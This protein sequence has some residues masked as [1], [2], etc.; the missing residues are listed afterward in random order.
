MRWFHYWVFWGIGEAPPPFY[1]FKITLILITFHSGILSGFDSI[2]TKKNLTFP[3]IFVDPLWCEKNPHRFRLVNWKG[4]FSPSQNYLMLFIATYFSRFY[5]DSNRIYLLFA[6][7]RPKCH[8]FLLNGFSLD[9][10]MFQEQLKSR[11]CRRY[12]WVNKLFRAGFTGWRACKKNR[13]MAGRSF[14]GTVQAKS[15]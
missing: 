3:I 13:R 10:I 7:F 2:L 8:R 6:F 4:I 1:G 14:L 5:C 9:E 11:W 12:W 15:S